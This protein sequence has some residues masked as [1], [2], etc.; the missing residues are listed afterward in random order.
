MPTMHRSRIRSVSNGMVAKQWACLSGSG[1]P[2]GIH[3]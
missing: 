1:T 3:G 2:L